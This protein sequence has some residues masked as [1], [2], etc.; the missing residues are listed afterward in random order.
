[1]QSGAQWCKVMQEDVMSPELIAVLRAKHG[2][3]EAATPD[4]LLALWRAL[5]PDAQAAYQLAAVKA[6]KNGKNDKG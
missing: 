5:P 4:Q 1:M 3:F 6:G 2:G